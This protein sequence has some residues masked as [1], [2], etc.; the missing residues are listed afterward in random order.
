MYLFIYMHTYR[1]TGLFSFRGLF[2]V[3]PKSSTR[4]AY[5][6]WMMGSSYGYTLEG[7]ETLV[8]RIS[9]SSSSC[10]CRCCC[11]KSYNYFIVIFH[12]HINIDLFSLQES[13]GT[14]FGSAARTFRD[15]GREYSR[16][17]PSPHARTEDQY[18]LDFGAKTRQHSA[19]VARFSFE[20]NS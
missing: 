7:K 3:V 17:F 9:C 20:F 16:N 18:I 4:R 12:I 2:C 15:R 14:S 6:C 10:C 1:I 19:R 5:M 11:S 13:R 8:Y